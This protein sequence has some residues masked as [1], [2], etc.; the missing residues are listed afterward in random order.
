MGPVTSD[1]TNT[2]E[3]V[4]S[5]IG[6][7]SIAVTD[8][9]GVIDELHHILR[10]WRLR[11]TD[12]SDSMG[13]DVHIQRMK[14]GFSWESKRLPKPKQWDEIPPE[15]IMNV[16]SD[17][18]DVIFDWYLLANP[19]IPCLHAGAVSI[20]DDLFCFPS[21]RTSGKSSLCMEL[22]AAGHQFYCDDVL[23]VQPETLEGL[24]MG[25]APMVRLPFPKQHSDRLRDFVAIRRG[26]TGP[27]WSYMRLLDGEIAP[28]GKRAKIRHLVLLDRG[29]RRK[30]RLTEISAAEML[31]ELILQ[32][33]GGRSD[34]GVVLE[35]L[36]A[37]VRNASCLKLVYAEARD[38]RQ[39]LE[40][41]GGSRSAR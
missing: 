5:E 41:L 18:H 33:F 28:F 27:D 23:P 14:G 20:G 1:M 36:H 13:A 2:T 31:K 11:R 35:T 32:N 34:P 4:V 15:T 10:G 12:A 40:G 39:L 21:V 17:L 22:V 30:A 6:Q 16:V 19:A 37:L 38:A 3:V 8:S 24:A 9:P 25:V 29:P 26:L 7:W